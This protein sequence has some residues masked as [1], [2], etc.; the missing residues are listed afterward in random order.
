M[1]VV[2]VAHVALLPDLPVPTAGGDAAAARFWPIEDL[3]L[4]EEGRPDSPR[5]AFD[6]ACILKDALERVRSK[7]EYT[8]LASAF[9]TE[10]FS[11][12]D[13][14]R[15]YLAV[16]GH[17]PDPANFRRKVLTTE[18]FVVPEG[19]A[20]ASGSR[21]RPPLLYTRGPADYLHPPILRYETDTT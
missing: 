15:V 13:L 21:G 17:A 6:Y 9:C 2:S 18:G 4:Q 14:R 7:L 5:I 12:A 19:M 3:D 10:P 16:W 8:T 20:E 1:R 11:L